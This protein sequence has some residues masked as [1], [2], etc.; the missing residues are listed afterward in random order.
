MFYESVIG[1][2]KIKILFEDEK[3]NVLKKF[4][5]YY[6]KNEDIYFNFVVISRILVYLFEVEEMIVKKK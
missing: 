5:R 3:I 2:G 6:Y 1:R 4:M